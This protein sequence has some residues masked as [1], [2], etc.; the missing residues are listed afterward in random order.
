MKKGLYARTRRAT[1]QWKC[2]FLILLES[3]N[4][5]LHGILDIK[6]TLEVVL[7]S[8]TTMLYGD[9]SVVLTKRFN[10]DVSCAR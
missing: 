1:L 7:F 10:I 4:S 3:E 6:I 2:T 8:A 5:A 9:N